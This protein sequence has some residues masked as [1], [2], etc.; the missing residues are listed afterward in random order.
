[1]RRIS[2]MKIKIFT[3][4]DGVCRHI[5]Q[6]R[7]RNHNKHLRQQLTEYVMEHYSDLDLGV[8]SIAEAFQMS[9]ITISRAFKSQQGETLLDFIHK[10]RVDSAKA[11]LKNTKDNIGTVSEKVG[12]GNTNTFIRIFKKYEGVTPGKYRETVHPDR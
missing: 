6:I 4:I 3:L 11:L 8:S 10:T 1:M 2:D 7:S 5:L 9:S 12:Y